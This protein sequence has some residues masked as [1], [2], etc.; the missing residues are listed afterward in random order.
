M[1]ILFLYPGHKL[2]LRLILHYYMYNCIELDFALL[3]NI[4]VMVTLDLIYGNSC[5]QFKDILECIRRTCF[6]FL[7]YRLCDIIRDSVFH[8]HFGFL[9]HF[10]LFAS[11]LSPMRTILYFFAVQYYQMNHYLNSINLMHIYWS[12]EIFCRLYLYPSLFY[13]GCWVY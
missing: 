9:H 13:A 1:L 11:S 7:P 6:P 12:I 2:H 8:K 3:R 5:N 10:T 4:S